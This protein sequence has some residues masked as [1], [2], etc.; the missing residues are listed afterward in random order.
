MMS[1]TCHCDI[2]GTLFKIIILFSF[3]MLFCKK[4]PNWKNLFSQLESAKKASWTIFG[5]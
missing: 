4:M 5:S 3:L 1:M 2:C